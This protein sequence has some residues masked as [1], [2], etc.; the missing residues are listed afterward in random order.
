MLVSIAY[1]HMLKRREGAVFIYISRAVIRADPEQ[2][3][4]LL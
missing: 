3:S 1:R 2:F 4:A